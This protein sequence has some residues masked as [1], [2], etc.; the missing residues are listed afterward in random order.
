MKEREVSGTIIVAD[1]LGLGLEFDERQ[2][3]LLLLYQACIFNKIH[4]K[5]SNIGCT[6]RYSGTSKQDFSLKRRNTMG[7][8]G[9][10]VVVVV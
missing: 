3:R 2:G 5:R 1:A 7:L 4:R 10:T 9:L 6:D 8:A